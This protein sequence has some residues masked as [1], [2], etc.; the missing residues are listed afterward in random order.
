MNDY[1]NGDYDD[2]FNDDDFHD[3]LILSDGTIVYVD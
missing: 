3:I 1:D 2:E